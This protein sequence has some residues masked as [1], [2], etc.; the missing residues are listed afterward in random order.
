MLLITLLYAYISLLNYKKTLLKI[1]DPT[2]K[3][4]L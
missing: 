1:M 4:Y 2:K 3:L